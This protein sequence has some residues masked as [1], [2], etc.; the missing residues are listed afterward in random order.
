[1]PIISTV[2]FYT[3]RKRSLEWIYTTYIFDDV[4]TALISIIGSIYIFHLLCKTND[5]DEF[6]EEGKRNTMSD[7]KSIESLAQQ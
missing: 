1:M 2:V 5:G 7:S 4:S 3:T 6:P